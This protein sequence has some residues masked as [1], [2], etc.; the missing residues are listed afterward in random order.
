MFFFFFFSSRRRHTRSL[1]DWSSDVC[2]SDLPSQGSKAR[3]PTAPPFAV[4]GHHLATE[5]LQSLCAAALSAPVHG[6][7]GPWDVWCP[8]STE[9]VGSSPPPLS[10][11]P[12]PDIPGSHPL[13]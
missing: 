6:A 10:S 5:A 13:P 1:C 7:G 2:S 9:P 3:A 4:P 12:V 8:P 11:G